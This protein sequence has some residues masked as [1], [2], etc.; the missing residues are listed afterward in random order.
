MAANVARIRKWLAAP[1]TLLVCATALAQS[2]DKIT[3]FN[4]VMMNATFKILGRSA[5]GAACGTGFI[6]G[7]PRPDDPTL[8]TYVAVTAAHVFEGIAGDKATLITRVRRDKTLQRHEH[9]I[10]IRSATGRPFYVKHPTADVVAMFIHL[11]A[12]VELAPIPISFLA[13]DTHFEQLEI[14]PGDEMLTPGYPYCLEGNDLGFPILRSGKVASFPLTP[15]ASIQKYCSI[16]RRSAG[17]AA[18]RF[19]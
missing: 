16:S 10:T 17:I 5:T 6:M 13:T 7:I 4:T 8:G 9:P 2:P 19:T 3:D 11:P 18:V 14:H 12:E 1:L 15:A